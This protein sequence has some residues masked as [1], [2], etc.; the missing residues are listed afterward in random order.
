MACLLQMLAAAKLRQ[1]FAATQAMLRSA[2]ADGAILMNAI[3][4]AL[5]QGLYC[6]GLNALERGVLHLDTM[7]GCLEKEILAS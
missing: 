1:S 2:A 4:T 6:P 7:P 5:L 3:E